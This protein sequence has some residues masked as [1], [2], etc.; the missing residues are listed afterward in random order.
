[1]NRTEID[2]LPDVMKTLHTRPLFVMHLDVAPIEVVGATALG[3]RRIGAVT[4]GWF[5]GDR[6]RGTVV[7]GSDWQTVRSDGSV[8]LDVR[9]RLRIDD[10]SLLL[11]SYLGL[12]HGPPA[13]LAEIDRGAVVDPSSYYFRIAPTFEVGVGQH[14]W[15]N[16]I[17][18]AGIG[19][20]FADGPLYSVFELL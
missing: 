6:L 13:V 3:T 17:L 19:H 9:I 16:S 1:M 20:R 14:A 12:R 18:A 8:S 2:Q 11:M 15:L 5:E 4:G 10:G 7:G